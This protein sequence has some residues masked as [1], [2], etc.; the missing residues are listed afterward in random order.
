MQDIIDQLQSFDL[1]FLSG[2]TGFI[3]VSLA[4]ALLCF[5][6]LR[7]FGRTEQPQP[8]T[9]TLDPTDDK[10]SDELNRLR[11]IIKPRG[12][13]GRD[14]EQIG[15][16]L[17]Q[18]GYYRPGA[19]ST[20]LTIRTL[21]V[22][23]PVF[24]AGF[25]AFVAPS[26]QVP[27]ILLVGVILA[28]LGF[29]IPRVIIGF[30]ARARKRHIERGLPVALDLV[31]LGLLAGQNV[32]AAFRRVADDI[33]PSFPIL[34]DEMALTM[35]QA[36]LNTFPHALD[37]WAARSG[38]AEV[39]TLAL[40][41]GQA[42]RLGTDTSTSMLELAQTFR[43]SMRQRA[44]GQANR[45]VFWMLFPTIIC[46]WLPAAVILVSP[47]IFEFQ[48]RRQQSREAMSAPDMDPSKPL[49]DQY[50]DL[51]KSND[52]F[53]ER[54]SRTMNKGNGLILRPGQ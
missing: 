40:T 8:L 39:Q 2:W 7:A 6:L 47:I 13:V 5:M 17:L 33:R 3:I 49:Q 29:S 30:Q 34:A 21:L 44:D 19:L 46:M 28:A 43:T 37:E 11:D 1:N 20:Y 18:A 48:Q 4:I 42:E 10:V 53:E 15:P 50:G 35:K 23:V 14:A 9:P 54:M 32:Q 12:N 27:K 31:T 51:L 41:L 52:Q 45:A 38:V 24:S 16:E 36:D 26:D 22:A 25:L